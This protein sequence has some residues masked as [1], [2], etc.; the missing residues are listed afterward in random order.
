[1]QTLPGGE[2]IA[3]ASARHMLQV[4][5][6]VHAVVRPGAGPLREILGGLGCRVGICEHADSGMAASLVAGLRQASG[7]DAWLIALADMPYVRQ[8]TLDAL[9]RALRAGADIV[10]PWCRGHGGNPVGFARRHL[11]QLLELEGDQGARALLREHPVTKVEVDDAGI[12]RDV[13]TVEDLHK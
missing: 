6:T 9:V 8:D 11:A 4:L 3:A 5:P 1:M 10:Q 13:D 12:F 2:H 7:A